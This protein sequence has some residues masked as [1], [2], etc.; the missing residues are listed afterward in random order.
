MCFPGL[1]ET[2]TYNQLWC[3][4]PGQTMAG[5]RW[6]IRHQT[7]IGLFE[8]EGEVSKKSTWGIPAFFLVWI[9]KPQEFHNAEHEICGSGSNIFKAMGTGLIGHVQYKPTILIYWLCPH[10]HYW[11][12]WVRSAPLSTRW[13]LNPF[14]AVCKTQRSSPISCQAQYHVISCVYNCIYI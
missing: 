3:N 5:W 6:E 13:W 1:P 7:A 12:L 8:P 9:E 2:G 14:M 11:N 10:Q 4:S